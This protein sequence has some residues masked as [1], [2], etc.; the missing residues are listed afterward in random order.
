[1]SRVV[2]SFLLTQTS[3]LKF[4]SELV[5]ES[6]TAALA[7][8]KSEGL[9]QRSDRSRIDYSEVQRSVIWGSMTILRGR[10][11]ATKWE[12]GF[13]AGG[14]HRGEER[15]VADATGIKGNAGDERARHTGLKSLP[16]T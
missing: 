7:A 3:S 11:G 9:S 16:R 13:W 14:H 12:R 4:Q 15:A 10:F 6:T 8:D 1:L 2:D 5:V